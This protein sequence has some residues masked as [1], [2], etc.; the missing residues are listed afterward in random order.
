[1]QKLLVEAEAKASTVVPGETAAVVE[2]ESKSVCPYKKEK[3]SER[4]ATWDAGKE[5]GDATEPA[6]WKRM[7]TIINGDAEQKGSYKLPHHRGP[8]GDYETVFKGV[9]AALG[10]LEQTDASEEDIAGARKHLTKHR[11]EF[12]DSFDAV[13]FETELEALGKH[14]R[15]AVSEGSDFGKLFYDSLIEQFVESKT[16]LPEVP[17]AV[18]GSATQKDAPEN[19]AV[20]EP[21]DGG[22]HTVKDFL[23]A[24]F[25]KK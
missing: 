6:Q 5:M 1:V 22:N 20:P 21:N 23:A 12:G 19:A 3:T 2:E 9:V 10:R 24:L 4:D 11:A 16:A 25:E 7:C 18:E 17:P 8:S 15:A 13:T 14:Y